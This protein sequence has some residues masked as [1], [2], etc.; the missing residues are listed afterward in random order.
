M[1]YDKQLL[2]KS[3]PYTEVPYV[4]EYLHGG[5]A[6]VSRVEAIYAKTSFKVSLMSDINHNCN[7]M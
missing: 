1:T 6:P 7:F 5:P 2:I 4:T 3:V